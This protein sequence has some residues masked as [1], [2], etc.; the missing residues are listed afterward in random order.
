VTVS[1]VGSA[2]IYAPSHSRRCPL[3]TRVARRYH[4]AVMA[5]QIS[6]EV[7]LASSAADAAAAVRALVATTNT[8]YIVARQARL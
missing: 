8:M 7:T 1:V 5:G 6:A 3:V 2:R 4:V